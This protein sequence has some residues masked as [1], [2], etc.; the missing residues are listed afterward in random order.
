M[1]NA[2]E[3]IV[4]VNIL[5]KFICFQIGVSCLILTAKS[6]NWENG[7]QFLPHYQ[8]T[9]KA[10]STTR[11]VYS[12][13]VAVWAYKDSSVAECEASWEELK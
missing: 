9:K 2:G 11:I 4:F 7:L 5:C 3:F 10:P 1:E 12:R 8:P 6:G 13:V